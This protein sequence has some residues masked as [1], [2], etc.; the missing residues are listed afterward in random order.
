MFS[1]SE[2]AKDILDK[3]YL[4]SLGDGLAKHLNFEVP[5]SRVERY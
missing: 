1:G 4:C 5:K 2:G 3:T